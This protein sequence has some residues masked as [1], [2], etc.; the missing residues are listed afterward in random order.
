[1]SYLSEHSPHR[2]PGALT[3]SFAAGPIFVACA[4]LAELCRRIPQAID[5]ETG[6]LLVIPTILLAS[7]IG[8]FLVSIIPN[9]L[10]TVLMVWA[11]EVL[12]PLRVPAAWA[13][14][15]GAI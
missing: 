1:M 5:V 7:T 11:G 2:L 15:G 6:G 14:V 4:L 3:A 8:G 9:L 13:A 10:G 12:P